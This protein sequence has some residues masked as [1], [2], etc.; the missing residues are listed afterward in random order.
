MSPHN[1]LTPFYKPLV[2]PYSTEKGVDPIRLANLKFYI[3]RLH[4]FAW[5]APAKHSVN[6]VV[7]WGI[8]MCMSKIIFN[9]SCRRPPHWDMS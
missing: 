3:E 8:L 7:S 1:H 5:M 9:P 6:G 2:I 4:R